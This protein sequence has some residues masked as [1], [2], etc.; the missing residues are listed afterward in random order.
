M[1]FLPA[2]AGADMEMDISTVPIPDALKK[3]T[4]VHHGRLTEAYSYLEEHVR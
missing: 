4:V 3:A 1:P 2:L